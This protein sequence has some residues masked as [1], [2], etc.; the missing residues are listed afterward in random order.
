MDV[1]KCLWVEVHLP[2]PPKT[3][4][5]R[6]QKPNVPNYPA[7]SATSQVTEGHTRFTAVTVNRLSQRLLL[8]V[9]LPVFIYFSPLYTDCVAIVACSLQSAS[10]VYFWD[11]YLQHRLKVTQ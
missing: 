2:L 8:L 3:Q 10:Y 7:L 5:L 4:S 9:L 11:L 6:K 1:G